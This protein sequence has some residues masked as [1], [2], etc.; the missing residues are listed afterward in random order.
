MSSKLF[1]AV[2]AGAVTVGVLLLPVTAAQAAPKHHPCNGPGFG[3][4]AFL[5]DG[6]G[7]PD[8]GFGFADDGFGFSGGDFGSG[9]S[10]GDLG[11]GFPDGD[12][13]SGDNQTQPNNTTIIIVNQT[14]KKKHHH[15]PAPAD[16][17]TGSAA[18]AGYHQPM[19]T[20]AGGNGCYHKARKN[21]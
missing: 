16:A 11:S 8:D 10:G 20:G 13:G 4:S 12:F 17:P 6:F 5:G 18:G 2:F 21:A 3:D 15:K 1:K 7:F 19:D 14:H 9:F